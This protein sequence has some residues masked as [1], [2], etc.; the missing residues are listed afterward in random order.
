MPRVMP[1]RK[2]NMRYT[3]E[4]ISKDIHQSC[5][6]FPYY[7][8]YCNLTAEEQNSL[9]QGI[10]D[11]CS[12]VPWL[13]TVGAF[14]LIGVLSLFMNKEEFWQ[15]WFDTVNHEEARKRNQIFESCARMHIDPPVVS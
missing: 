14:E 9:N 13:G 4:S 3:L 12:T 7:A 11:L 5:Q 6:H 2:K 10:F 15:L 8:T 1:L